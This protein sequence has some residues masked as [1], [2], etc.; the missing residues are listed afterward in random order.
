[1]SISMGSVFWLLTAAVCLIFLII[2]WRVKD[3]AN[4]SFS[5]YAIGAGSFNLWLIFFTQFA[6]IM[7]VSNFF[8]HAGNSY[9]QGLGILAFILGEQGSKI[10]FALTVAGLIGRFTYNTLPELID[11]LIVR[12]KLTRVMASVMASLIMIASVGSQAKAFGDLFEVFTGVS[13]VPIVILFSTIFILYTVFGGVYSVVWTDLFQGI[14]CL[15][16]G[17]MFYA[18]MF[19]RVDF[20]LAVLQERLAAV[21]EAELMSFSGVSGLSALNKFLTGLVGVMIFQCYWQRCFG[22]R[23][24][25]DAKRSMLSS[26]LICLVFVFMTAFSGLIIMTYNQGLN[27]NNAMPWFMMHIM[28]KW[29]C[30][31]IFVLVLCAGMSTADSCLNSAA[32]LVV[33]DIIHPFRKDSDRKLIR[34][35]KIA[36][37]VIGAAACFCGVYAQTI[38]SLLSKAYSFAGAGV[39]PVITIGLLWRERKEP[40]EMGRRN[41][42]VTPWGARCG[43]VSGAVLSQLPVFGDYAVIAAVLL[44][45][46][47]IV[48][49]SL[50][51]KHVPVE[52]IFRSEGNVHPIQKGEAV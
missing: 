51:T 39:V 33:N 8:S 23:N 46:L 48:I 45:S 9:E 40:H 49:V 2:S 36:T 1:M 13:S 18:F 50:L 52:K 3:K 47:I 11:D 31:C 16:F 35:S 27:A 34:E 37:V 42:R 19:S 21:G 44:S 30:A 25:R 17:I 28:P 6:S 20:S 41:S 10:V 4:Q 12:D 15:V 7:G 26:G 43:I 5:D 32:V 24:G 14:M 22:C 29:L 38:L